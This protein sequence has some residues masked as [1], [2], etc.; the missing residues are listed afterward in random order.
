VKVPEQDLNMIEL[1]DKV[2][3]LTG[4]SSG[5]GESLAYELA[6][7][8]ATLVLSARRESVLRDVQS[9]CAS[10]QKHLVLPLDMLQPQAFEPAVRTVLGRYGH[11]DVLL[12]AAGL[13]Q[14]GRAADTDIRVD[15]HLMELNFLGPVGL[16]KQVLPSMIARRSG[17]IVVISSLLGKFGAQERSAYSASKHA[18]HGFFDSLRAE[19]YRDGIAVTIICPGFVCTNA[20]YNALSTDGTPH[21]Q[22]DDD[23][24][25]GMPSEEAARQIARAI[26]RR[27]REVYI[28]GSER[29]AVYLSRFGPRLF[30]RIIRKK[31]LK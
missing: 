27:R 18:L 29:F 15:R 13:S 31:K 5:I 20:S 22:M 8:G 4:A 21:G 26:E 14:R 12:L 9:R 17:H 7:K 19:V 25:R 24:S 3:W 2:V 16:S 10:S 1:K 23:I 11:I 6:S 30:S 28:G